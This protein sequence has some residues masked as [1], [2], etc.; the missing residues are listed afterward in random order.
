[1]RRFGTLIL[2]VAVM[3]LFAT[4]ASAQDLSYPYPQSGYYYCPDSPELISRQAEAI[5]EVLSKIDS[6]QRRSMLAEQWFQLSKQALARSLDFREQWLA[7]QKQQVTNDEE[8]QRVRVEMLRMEGEI[9]KLRSENLKL[10]NENLQLQLLLKQQTNGQAPS[11]QAPNTQTPNS[12]T[13]NA[14]TPSATPQAR[15]IS[16]K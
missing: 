1:M 15:T 10:Q 14:Q 2:P 6:P 13:P 11:G 16:A 3:G 5:S 12:Q 8:A 7:V 9:E 4:A